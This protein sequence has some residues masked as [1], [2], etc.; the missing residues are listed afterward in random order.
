MVDVTLDMIGELLRSMFEL[1]WMKP[2]GLPASK[3]LASLPDSPALAEP[4]G[5]SRLPNH[6]SKKEQTFRLATLPLVRAGWLVR[7]DKGRW[8]LTQEGRQ[9]GRRFPTAQELYKEAVRLLEESQESAPLYAIALEQA[10]ES[11]WALIQKYLQESRRVQFQTLIADLLRAMGYHLAWIAP[12]EKDHGQIDMVAN[13]D[14]LGAKGS[15]IL[16]QVKTKGQAVTM[17]GLK[18][19][20]A[21]LGAG[22]Y[23]LLVSTGGFTRDVIQ[24][25]QGDTFQKTTLLDLEGFFDLWIKHF[26]DLDQ[27]A[28]NRFPLKAVY[29]LYGL[30]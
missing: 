23:G 8:S 29:F 5:E 4:E 9:A 25:V 13:V 24:Q 19:F 22:D 20:L 12:P 3:I 30:E 15:R 14:P 11:A 7:N 10:A 16:V 18:S 26:N 6:V 1:L 28:R 27:E 21:V 17:E 2:E